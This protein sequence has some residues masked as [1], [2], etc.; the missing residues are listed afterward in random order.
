[1]ITF[2]FRPLKDWPR[3][4]TRFRKNSPFKVGFEATLELLKKE[5]EHVG[6]RE[7]VVEADILP[8]HIRR[9][10]MP[11]SDALAMSPKILVRFQSKHGPL[12]FLC[13]DCRH[14]QDNL[15]AIA[16]TLERLRLADLYG[17]T[18]GGE[19]YRGW[20][21]LPAPDS[22]HFNT[23]DAAIEWVA[24]ESGKFEHEL[25]DATNFKSAFRELAKKF[26]TDSGAGDAVKF[27]KLNNARDLVEKNLGV[28]R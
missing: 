23:V 28:A 3:E 18:K 21:A 13:D 27:R 2:Q 20:Q 24:K 6:G 25:R 12:D 5:I 22:E 16:L 11:R 26:H 14:W 4:A 15:R 8:N 17:V 1:M 19:Q 10:G 7:V 9:D